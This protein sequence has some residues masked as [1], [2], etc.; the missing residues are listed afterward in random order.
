MGKAK[1]KSFSFIKAVCAIGI[2]VFHFSCYLVNTKFRPLY[3]YANGSWGSAI[4]VV[5]FVV[6][7]AL[8]FYNYEHKLKTAG[9]ISYYWKRWKAIFPMYYLAYFSFE[10]QNVVVNK[11]LFFRG[12][13]WRYVFTLLGM[14]G[15]FSQTFRTYYILG[16]WFI[17]PLV[18]LYLIFP[19]FLWAMS[20]NGV[21][22]FAVT[23]GLYVLLANNTV[24]NPTPYSSVTYCLVAF[25]FG[26]L[27]MKYK[28][29]L[30]NRW[31][32]II[33]LI[34]FSLIAFI[35]LPITTECLCLLMGGCLF[36]LLFS[37]GEW[38][39]KNSIADKVFTEIGNISYAC[40]LLQHILIVNVLTAWNPDNPIKILILLFATIGLILLQA[41]V[42]TIVNTTFMNWLSTFSHNIFSRKSKKQKSS[43]VVK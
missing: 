8:L 32:A 25:V 1:I 14:D 15:Y 7:G 30:L 37:L 33:S 24:I 39:M 11:S 9:I 34:I 13:P 16:E 5:F 4:V 26:M 23:L 28:K 41:K 31:T 6:S 38:L 29:Q 18:M 20:K 42:L 10:L 12:A 43:D 21:I 17:G 3:L 22:T 27:V 35:K 19:I 36:I 40:F 2:I